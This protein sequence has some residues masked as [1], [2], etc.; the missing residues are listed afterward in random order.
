MKKY[1]IAVGVAFICCMLSACSKDVSVPDEPMNSIESQVTL[2]QMHIKE[3]NIR[4]K[5]GGEAVFTVML[6]ERVTGEITE[7]D[8]I[9]PKEL[10]G[11]P[12]IM[13]T[14]T[15]DIEVMLLNIAGVTGKHYITI[16]GEAL[17][18][19][20][21]LYVP[22][23]LDNGNISDMVTLSCV[24]STTSVTEGGMLT[25]LLSYEGI[26][27]EMNLGKISITPVGFTADI[28]VSVSSGSSHMLTLT[29]IHKEEGATETYL[30]ICEG[31]AYDLNNAPCNGCRV[32]II[33][34]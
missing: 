14:D 33:I 10:T 12:L 5:L 34:D 22:I 28:D 18:A 19:V 17:G 31:T 7:S 11:T 9:F 8:I 32:D 3:S 27:G 25:G 26:V 15:G 1:K 2:E 23:E 30:E 16:R 13:P 6:P 20:E 21:D 29:N 4:G 24:P